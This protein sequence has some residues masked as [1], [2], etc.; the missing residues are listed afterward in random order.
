MVRMRRGIC[1]RRAMDNGATASGGETIAPTVKP[2]GQDSCSHRWQAAAT[3]T[4]VNSTQPT[5]SSEMPP[6][7]ARKSFQLMATAAQ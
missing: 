6:R 7:L 4:V 5:A 3:S 2:T 1:I